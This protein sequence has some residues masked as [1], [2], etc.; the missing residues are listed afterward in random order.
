MG[1][2]TG[3]GGGDR[4]VGGTGIPIHDSSKT[5]QQWRSLLTHEAPIIYTQVVDPKGHE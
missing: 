4:K 2:Y 3:E 1:R 5:T